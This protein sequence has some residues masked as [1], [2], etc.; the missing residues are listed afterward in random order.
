MSVDFHFLSISNEELNAIKNIPD[1]IMELVEE[2]NSDHLW[3]GPEVKA[4][5]ALTA[6]GPEDPL[7]FTID[8]APDNVAGY[9]GTFED[10]DCEIDMGYGPCSYFLN[11]FLIQV[12]ERLKLF[13]IETFTESCDLEWLE[14]NYF[15]PTG[16]L[17]D[18]RK[19][20]LVESYSM[21]KEYVQ[22]AA[23]NGQHLLVWRA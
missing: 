6:E 3:L 21:Y 1:S 9:I 23:N 8:G 5:V 4:I 22:N 20:D 10:G 11:S 17:E 13:T 14:E 7:S 15:A 2:R 19:E 12:S 16:W 18:G